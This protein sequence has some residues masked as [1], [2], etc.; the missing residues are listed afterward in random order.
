MGQEI[1]VQAQAA[2]AL[3]T[4]TPYS[5]T[6]LT[7]LVPDWLGRGLFEDSDFALP[8]NM[9]TDG[10][11][12]LRDIALRFRESLEIR[13]TR[14]DLDTIL[15]ELRLRTNIR[16]EGVDE[17][18]AR[19]RILRDDCRA[20]A[21]E[22]LREACAAYARENK[23]FPAGYGELLPFITKA[24]N[25]RSR[26]A[27]HLRRAAEKADAEIELR[28][29]IADDPVPPEEFAA[30]LADMDR[31]IGAAATETKK[32]DYSNLQIPTVEAYMEMGVS[33]EDAEAAVATLKAGRA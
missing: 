10:P 5:L 2:T 4:V 11:K 1:A 29:K 6:S 18:R 14:E 12:Q 28:R 7:A 25:A 17:S 16:N 33:R 13:P 27:Y 19:F 15:G 26:T 20:H 8:A 32:R 21:T 23:F 3:G 31:K 30:L 22:V 24:E 9:P